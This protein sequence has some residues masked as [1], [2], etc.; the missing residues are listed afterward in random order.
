MTPSARGRGQAIVELALILPILLFLLLGCVEAGVF[1]VRMIA[2]QRLAG[3]MV[4]AAVADPSL[5]LPGWWPAEASRASCGSPAVAWDTSSDPYRLVLSC[6]YSPLAVPGWTW[7]PS[8][9]AIAAIP[10]EVPI[11][12]PA[13]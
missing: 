12:T 7:R 11:E 10:P 9:E 5:S 3:A 4:D 13:P 6:S 8:V 1:S 2:W